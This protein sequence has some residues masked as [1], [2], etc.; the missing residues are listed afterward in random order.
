MN[1]AD[2]LLLG[3]V[4]AFVTGL[5]TFITLAVKRRRELVEQ[6]LRR[7]GSDPTIR[8]SDPSLSSSHELILGGLTPALAGTVP[9]GT[10]DQTELQREL[11]S[12]G[13]YRPTALM[14]YA[15][16]RAVLVIAP[17]IAAGVFA[18]FTDT[19]NDALWIWVPA[20]VVA[21]LGYSIPRVYLYFK[22]KARQHVIERGLPTAIDM[23]TLCLSAGL[24]VLNSL[25]RVTQELHLAFPELALELEIV[26]R[27]AELRTLEFALS[28]FADRVG[29]PQ[30]RNLSV[31]LT[32]S[33]NLGT[34]AVQVLREYADNL[35]INM[36]QRADEMANK[37]P[38]K[39]LFP[40]YMMAFGAGILLISPVV[41]EFQSFRR[42]NMIGSSITQA[43]DVLKKDSTP[44]PKKK[45]AEEE[46][47]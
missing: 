29:M 2:W 33:E 39:L 5:C 19:V 43:R 30:I 21:I 17:L 40:A 27:Q 28:Q 16:L 7:E 20:I 25:Q 13:Y 1:P 47:P 32:Q 15:A 44:A 8:S 14:E 24:N 4:F 9:M 23:L 37:A 3:L 6:R 34:D 18:L 45:T 38:F 31:L 36:R 26:R 22:A 41:L 11:R 42:T 46:Q 12:A 35:R 10:E